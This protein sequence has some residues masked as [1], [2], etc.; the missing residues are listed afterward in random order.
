MIRAACI[1][2]FGLLAIPVAADPVAQAEAAAEELRAAAEA[3]EAADRAPDRVAALTQTVHAYEAG[4]TSLRQGLRAATLREAELDAEFEA[5]RETLGRLIGILLSMQTSPEAL[6]LLHPA[7][8]VETA[9]AGMV[10][11][12]V[13]PGLRSEVEVLKVKLEEAASL[14]AVQQ[15]AADMLSEGLSGIQS[16]RSELSKAIADRTDLPQAVATDVAAMQALVNSADTLEGFASSLISGGSDPA[17]EAFAKSQ[18]TLPLP[19]AGVPLRRF[20]EADAAGIARPG[21]LLATRPRAMVTTPSAATVRYAGALLDY[22]KVI[23]LEPESGYLLVLAGLDTV[24]GQQGDVIPAGTAVG[25]M[26][27]ADPMP[28]TILIEMS[29]GGGQERT[30]TLYIELREGDDPVNPALWFTG[31]AGTGPE[32]E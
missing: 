9:R 32:N 1:I 25:L 28:E 24:F 27:G 21:I 4:L 14:R 15:N 13:V 3:L 11:S 2:A 31:I 8:P 29:Q 18:G 16:A 19:V 20:G 23:I 6:V 12:D 30:E 26:G 5:E 10:V 17:A 22:G 7:G